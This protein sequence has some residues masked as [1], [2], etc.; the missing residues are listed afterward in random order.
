MKPRFKLGK[1][2]IKGEMWEQ[3]N[4]CKWIAKTI[5]GNFPSHNV[6]ESHFEKPIRLPSNKTKKLDYNNLEIEFL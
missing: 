4:N 1:S 5:S 6:V 2:K 3:S